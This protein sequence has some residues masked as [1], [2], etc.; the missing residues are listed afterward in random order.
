MINKEIIKKYNKAVPRYTSYPPANFFHSGIS[1]QEFK[2]LVIQSNE[3]DPKAISL[4]FHIPFCPYLCH[5]C[6]CNS[7]KMPGKDKVE[8][9]INAMEK[10][11]MWL[12]GKLD[13]ERPVKQVHWGGGTPN[14]I[15]FRFIERIISKVKELFRVHPN[16]EVAIE[17][18]PG[19]LSREKL[20][21]LK[22]T[23]FNRISLGI[24]DVHE[25]VLDTIHRK[26]PKM[27]IENLMSRI[28]EEGFSSV[29]ADLVYGLPGQ[30]EGHFLESIRR[31]I[32]LQPERVVTFSYA[33]V[34]WVKE[35]QNKLN[36]LNRLEGDAKL[37]LF[38][39]GKSMLE[40]A[41]YQAL[42]LDH[43][44]LPGDP[45]AKA[46]QE[47]RLHRNFMGYALKEQ[48][49]QVYALGASGISQL[50]N[51]FIQ[52]EK[53]YEKYIQ[54]IQNGHIPARRGY[55]VSPD[56]SFTGE[57]ITKMMCNGFIRW[58]AIAEEQGTTTEQL[59]KI[60][61]FKAEKLEEM[62]KDGLLD[63]DNDYIKLTDQGWFFVRNVAALF[64]PMRKENSNL[65]SKSV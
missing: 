8:E 42:G 43:F 20:K 52:N 54:L 38:M 47:H 45:L 27:S 39:K 1:E 29:N 17:A 21:S 40:K 63:Y 34:P 16:A 51:A 44:A 32:P 59:K 55:V 9:Y 60:T 24:Q 64:D 36:E 3:Q 26:R 6:A 61:G 50:K 7:Y 46:F 13:D 48:T 35:K 49:G 12:A 28:R 30:T 4:Y 41:G 14:G 25:K 10:E 58:S 62:K 15:S 2:D 31:I 19:F 65:Y 56:Q 23:G 53:D 22:A 33:Y 5:F 18:H 57:V 11:L 37:A